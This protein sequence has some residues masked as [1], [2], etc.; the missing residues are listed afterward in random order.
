M[1]KYQFSGRYRDKFGSYLR[2]ADRP[3]QRKYSAVVMVIIAMGVILLVASK[4]WTTPS[5]ISRAGEAIGGQNA[6]PSSLSVRVALDYVRAIQDRDFRRIFRMTQWMQ[7]RVEHIRME[8]GSEAAQQRIDTFYQEEK[9]NFF[10]ASPGPSL[11][12]EGISDADL[13][14]PGAVVRVVDVKEGL[15]RPILNKG[16]PVNMVLLEIEYPLSVAA[17]TAA[18]EKRIDKLRAAL[19]LTV[20]GS[21]IKASVRGNAQVDPTSVLYRRLTPSETRRIRTKAGKPLIS[22]QMSSG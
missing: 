4:R 8:S 15:A 19:Y 9:E 5:E 18:D 21:V 1:A 2:A 12:L 20:D 10:A 6:P 11:T 16:E 13:F 7:D 22:Q 14:L 17:P 3:V